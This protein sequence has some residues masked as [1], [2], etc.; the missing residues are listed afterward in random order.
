M[1]RSGKEMAVWSTITPEMMSDEEKDGDMYIRHPPSYR[2]QNFLCK[3]DE[4]A[5]KTNTKSHARFQRKKGSPRMKTP[6]VNLK[7]WMKKNDETDLECLSDEE[8]TPAPTVAADNASSEDLFS[9][10]DLAI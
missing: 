3:L 4:R 9:D 5:D 10:A 1:V 8:E 6:P 7:K 2:S